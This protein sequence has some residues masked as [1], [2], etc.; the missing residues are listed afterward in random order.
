MRAALW[1]QNPELPDPKEWEPAAGQKRKRETVVGVWD[2]ISMADREM[3]PF[4]DSTIDKW[5]SK[6]MLAGNSGS[7]FKAL[8]QSILTQTQHVL[9]DMDRLLRRT[10]VKRSTYKVIGDTLEAPAQDAEEEGKEEDI[11]EETAPGRRSLKEE[12]DEEAYDDSD[13]Y[14]LLLR[15]LIEASSTGNNQASE[16]Q[17]QLRAARRK[18]GKAGKVV[19]T[20]ASKGRKLRY[21]VQPKLVNFMFPEP[22]SIPTFAEAL[23]NNIFKS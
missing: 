2:R 20:K 4:R 7:K 15:D 5:N 1:R 11:A 21:D 14:Q 13:F 18:A 19:D 3:I 9:E 17:A 16:L 23:F 12:V 22:D 8:N 10:R 6:V